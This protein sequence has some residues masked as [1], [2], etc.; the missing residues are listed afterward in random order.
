MMKKKKSNK[1]RA[2][3]SCGHDELGC[4]NPNWKPPA[5]SL[6]TQ[7]KEAIQALATE[8]AAL[9][10]EQAN[11]R[12]TDEVWA[13]VLKDKRIQMQ[14][15]VAEHTETITS[16]RRDIVYLKEQNKELTKRLDYETR[17]AAQALEVADNA[18]I[19]TACIARITNRLSCVVDT[20][21]TRVGQ[22]NDALGKLLKTTQ[23]LSGSLDRQEKTDE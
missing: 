12:K 10:E 14:N 13:G 9:L 17:R 1:L 4:K 8:Q 15:L 22:S 5:I 16:M 20:L 23:R 21:E 18:A 6:K 2:C 19:G 7:L 3:E 11:H